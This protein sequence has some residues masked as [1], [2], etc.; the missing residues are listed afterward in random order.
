MAGWLLRAYHVASQVQVAR[1]K[2]IVNVNLCTY[3]AKR[4]R[5]DHL[6][7]REALLIYV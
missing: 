7:S 4:L 6:Y 3:L 5:V 2:P 1:D